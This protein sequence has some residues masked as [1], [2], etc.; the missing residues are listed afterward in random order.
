MTCNQAR[1]PRPGSAAS[2]VEFGLQPSEKHGR[3]KD[4]LARKQRRADYEAEL[5]KKAGSDD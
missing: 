2:P 4:A 5:P 1:P 3:R